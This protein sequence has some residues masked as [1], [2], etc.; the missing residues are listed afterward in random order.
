M[1]SPMTPSK[2]RKGHILKRIVVSERNYLALKKLGLAGDSF[3]DVIGNLISIHR[4]YRQ[5]KDEKN[6]KE[7][8]QLAHQK[9]SRY[10]TDDD[11]S[12]VISNLDSSSF[13]DE[14]LEKHSQEMDEI[15]RAINEKREQ[16]HQ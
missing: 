16:K 12:D 11:L 15:F 8:H 6:P 5:E 2:G 4:K 3:N 7:Q 10:D 1:A 9:K 13:I 14:A